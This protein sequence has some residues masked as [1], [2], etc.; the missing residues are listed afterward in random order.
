MHFFIQMMFLGLIGAAIG[1]ITNYIAIV[2][3]FRPIEP[4]KIFGID[5]QGLI[6]RR[7]DEIAASIGK[8]VEDELISI[9]DIW[10]K[11]LSDENRKYIL[12]RILNTVGSAV[13][14]NVPSF[15]PKPLKAMI[16]DYV[17]GI[18]NKEAEKFIDESAAIMSEKVDIAG[19]VEEKIKL[20]ELKKLEKIVLDVSNKE[21]K[22]I[23][24]LGGIL[25][26]IIGILQAFVVRVL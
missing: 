10:G 17:R 4:V 26:F 16:A 20:F 18:V 24:V 15:I 3:L 6:P 23:V 21:L 7:R 13:E 14:K 9:D 25:G 12:S 2:M 1:W 8:V 5:I 19:I 11:L 22:M